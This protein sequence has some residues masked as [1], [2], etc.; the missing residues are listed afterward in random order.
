[1]KKTYYITVKKVHLNTTNIGQNLK[2]SDDQ[3]KHKNT[4]KPLTIHNE[5][6]T[7]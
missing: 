6:R 1:V 4:Q 7:T 5:L 2:A 3:V